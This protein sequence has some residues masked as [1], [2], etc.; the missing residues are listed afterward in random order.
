MHDVFIRATLYTPL[1]RLRLA[2]VSDLELYE[3]LYFI[4]YIKS[5]LVTIVGAGYLAKVLI[6]RAWRLASDFHAYFLA[7]M[8]I[9]RIDL[10][11]YGEW[12]GKKS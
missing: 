2:F 9:W 11:K 8:G 4:M 3:V 6:G 10:K 7:P 1:A 12:A 5:N